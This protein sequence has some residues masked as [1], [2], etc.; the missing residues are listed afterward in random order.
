MKTTPY[1]AVHSLKGLSAAH[2]INSFLKGQPADSIQSFQRL[3]TFYLEG[4]RF[5]LKNSS[6]P[7]FL[8]GSFEFISSMGGDFLIQFSLQVNCL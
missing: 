3:Y 6:I 7:Y 8:L 1:V 2:K 5:P 4:F